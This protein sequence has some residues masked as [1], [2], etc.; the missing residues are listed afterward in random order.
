M[1][2]RKKYAK[3]FLLTTDKEPPGMQSMGVSFPGHRAELRR[4]AQ[5]SGVEM[6]I[7]ENKQ[8]GP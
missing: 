8:H 6:G 1:G 5:I 7:H 2:I 4:A 3:P